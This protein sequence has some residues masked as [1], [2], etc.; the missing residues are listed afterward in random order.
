VEI[1]RRRGISVRVYRKEGFPVKKGFVFV[2]VSFSRFHQRRERNRS[3]QR[4]RLIKSVVA[5]ANHEG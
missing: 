3:V 5:E 2:C 4:Q 1:R